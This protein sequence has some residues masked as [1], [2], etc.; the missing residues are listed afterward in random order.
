MK[1]IS[2]QP[3]QQQD[4]RDVS[5][6]YI[7]KSNPW[8]IMVS[9]PAISK[10]HAASGYTPLKPIRSYIQIETRQKREKSSSTL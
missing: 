1:L 4:A 5:D 10:D 2:F 6:R 8:I 9:T 7:A 3:G